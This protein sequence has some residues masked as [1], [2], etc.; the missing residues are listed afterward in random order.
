MEIGITKLSTRGQIVIPNNIREHL[1]LTDN[2]QFIVMSDNDEI[3][4]K[5]IKEALKTGRKKSKHAEEFIKA[6]RHEMILKEMEKG[7]E[8]S[9]DDVL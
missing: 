9:A 1:G 8:L 4:L 2:D 3:I 5:P 7:K 6:M